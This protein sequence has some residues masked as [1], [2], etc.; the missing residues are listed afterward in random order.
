MLFFRIV[1]CIL[2]VVSACGCFL[3][4]GVEGVAVSWV[5]FGDDVRKG[6]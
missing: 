6:A 1:R 3:G 5:V 2:G 4:L